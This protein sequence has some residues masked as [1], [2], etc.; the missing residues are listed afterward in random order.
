MSNSTN[1]NVASGAG[2]GAELTAARKKKG[3]SV[4]AVADELN[5]LCRYVEAMEAENFS[6]LPEKAFTRGFVI[7]Y[8]K[9]VGLD[10]NDIVTKFLAA[11]PKSPSDNK[12]QSP[13]Q[14]MGTL[15]RGRAPIRLNMGLIAGIIALLVLG[16]AILKMINGATS[17][18]GTAEPTQTAVVDEL[19]ANAQAQGAAIGDTGVALPQSG[20]V[21]R[22]GVLDFWVKEA[23]AI[24]VTD[25]TGQVLMSGEQK[26]GGYQLAGQLPFQVEIAKPSSVD[27]NFNQQPVSLTEKAITLQ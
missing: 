26:R 18:Q 13:M 7:N 17:V 6:A 8:A 12:V 11:Y 2:F 9:L 27:L 20:D 19:S 25:A 3:L 23:V 4:Q 24:K 10:S 22:S 1:T 21:G 15:Q 16:V 14:P 5:I